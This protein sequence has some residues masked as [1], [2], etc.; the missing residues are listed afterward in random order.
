MFF[1][2]LF[3]FW[4]ITAHS[5]KILRAALF[6]NTVIVDFQYETATYREKDI[7]RYKTHKQENKTQKRN[8][9]NKKYQP[10]K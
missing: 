10:I 5:W 1:W 9:N 6:C 4:E 7:A 8:N 3:C 2:F